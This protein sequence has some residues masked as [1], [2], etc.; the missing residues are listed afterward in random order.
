MN[1]V[2]DKLVRTI[3]TGLWSRETGEIILL[4]VGLLITSIVTTVVFWGLYVGEQTPERQAA[5]HDVG[6]T[7]LAIYSFAFLSY[8]TFQTLRWVWYFAQGYNFANDSYSTTRGCAGLVSGIEGA[9]IVL[10]CSFFV[11]VIAV[12]VNYIVFFVFVGAV[13]VAAQLGIVVDIMPAWV[14][15]GIAV[16]VA[17]LGVAVAVRRYN[18]KRWAVFVALKDRDPTDA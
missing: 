10:L 9:G 3:D 15:V 13:F 4:T 8:V 1:F 12:I 5:L 2:P 18:Q 6:Y 16:V 7:I 17:A 11:S 14:L